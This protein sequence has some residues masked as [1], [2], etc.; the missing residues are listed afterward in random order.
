MNH[1]YKL[2]FKNYDTLIGSKASNQTALINAF[3]SFPKTDPKGPLTKLYS[4]RTYQFNP[5]EQTNNQYIK[6][7]SPQTISNL[8]SSLNPSESSPQ[9]AL[10]LVQEMGDLIY[11][12]YSTKPDETLL[13]EIETFITNFFSKYDCFIDRNP[14][15]AEMN[16]RF[17]TDLKA[18]IIFNN[19][20]SMNKSSIKDSLDLFQL[21]QTTFSDGD[22]L[23]YLY[24]GYRDVNKLIQQALKNNNKD[25]LYID[26]CN[27]INQ[28]ISTNRPIQF[29]FQPFETSSNTSSIAYKEPLSNLFKTN[30]HKRSHFNSIHFLKQHN[31]IKQIKHIDNKTQNEIMKNLRKAKIPKNYPT[32]IRSP[33]IKEVKEYLDK[34]YS[35]NSFNNNKLSDSCN[36]KLHFIIWIILS[37]ILLLIIVI[38]VIVCINRLNTHKNNT[39][40]E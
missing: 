39:R 26:N 4:E 35:S 18:K 5:K 19:A 6:P 33:I 27:I 30:D 14:T 22:V 3:K 17:D 28:V 10:P 20:L 24:A 15:E 40:T 7:L 2:N 21:A 36:N 38:V 12:C 32:K 23:I 9:T 29:K 1:K 34:K 13:N 25:V 16:A 11:K 8:K 31:L 37:L